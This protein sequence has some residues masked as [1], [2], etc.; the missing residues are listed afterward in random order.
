MV[1]VSG[2]FCVKNSPHQLT[3]LFLLFVAFETAHADSFSQVFRPISLVICDFCRRWDFFTR[4]KVGLEQ[5]LE[6]KLDLS[7]KFS[8]QENCYLGSIERFQICHN[9]RIM[10]IR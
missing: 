2:D 10:T 6:G 9:C 3:I 7:R 4:Q 8:D 5:G 1:D